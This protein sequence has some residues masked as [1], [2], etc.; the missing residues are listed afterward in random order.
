MGAAK[1]L[2]VTSATASA[3]ANANVPFLEGLAPRKYGAIYVTEANLPNSTLEPAANIASSF[4]A[5]EEWPQCASVIGR[6]RD[7][8]DCGA[9]WAFGTTTAM[10]DRLCI[11][12]GN[13][14][15]I[16][17]P[18]DT[19]TNADGQFGCGGGNPDAT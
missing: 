16:L 2:V 8:S 1:F 12:T 10:N 15:V 7:Q 3:A 17:S 11:A 19:L 18:W 4:D 14:D 5:R 13:S 6:I 9:C